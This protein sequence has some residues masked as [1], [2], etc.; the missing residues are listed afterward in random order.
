MLHHSETHFVMYLFLLL[1]AAG[2]SYFIKICDLILNLKPKSLFTE[3]IL[4]GFKTHNSEM[5][6]DILY[7]SKAT[8]PFLPLKYLVYPKRSFHG[9]FLFVYL[10]G[11]IFLFKY[12]PNSHTFYVWF[13][14]M[15]WPRC[16]VNSFVL[17]EKGYLICIC[18]E[19]P[20]KFESVCKIMSIMRD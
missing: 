10:V 2:N 8:E 11:C 4:V 5:F 7:T 18:L 3:C 9:C 17:G 6:N 16:W 19:K 20:K 14:A 12:R 15:M 1:P 13:C